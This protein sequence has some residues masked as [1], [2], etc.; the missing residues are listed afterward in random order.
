MNV[1]NR[2]SYF[3]AILVVA[4]FTILPASS[5]LDE[6]LADGARN[7]PGLKAA[8]Y[9][10]QAK[11]ESIAQVRALPDPQLSFAQFI[12]PIETRVG[13]QRQRIGLMQK[14][15]WFGKLKL[16]GDAASEAAEA[17]RMK[18]EFLKWELEFDIKKRY[19]AHYYLQRSIAILHEHLRLL[20]YLEG[21]LEARY[22]VGQVLLSD[23]LRIQ[24]ER[25]SL[26]DRLD[27]ARDRVPPL[28]AEL[29]VL[30]GRALG[31]PIH[32]ESQ[33]EVPEVEVDLQRLSGMMLADNPS[34]K[35]LGHSVD[36]ERLGKRL[37]RLSARPDFSLGVDYMLTGEAR[38]PDVMG[39]GTDPFAIKMSMSLPIWSKKNKAAA[40]EAEA[41]YQM[42]MSQKQDAESRLLAKLE[43]IYAAYGSAK[44][45]LKLY[46]H[47]LIPRALQ[48]MA[49]T[50][51]AFETG[52]TDFLHYIDALRTLLTLELNGEKAAVDA[53]TQMAALDLLTGLDV[54]DDREKEAV[55]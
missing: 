14:F 52:K 53:A 54:V 27:D 19:Y 3:F 4:L 10:W 18:L 7:N 6:L 17:A 28:E 31:T 21:V 42:A 29:N 48:A 1:Q 16:K 12:Q 34:L 13:P 2:F 20:K 55:N 50:Q 32:S 25:E 39:S 9:V 15:P 33:L 47:S 44:R 37:A 22:K 43:S 23:L 46:R 45:K 11:M 49:V 26:Q 41:R 8:F 30:A 38:M 5:S 24:I 35:A 51:T 36:L 40:R